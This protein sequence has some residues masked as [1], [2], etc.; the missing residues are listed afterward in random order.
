MPGNKRTTRRNKRGGGMFDGLL[1]SQQQSNAY[2]SSFG[3]SSLPV[4]TYQQQQPKQKSMFDSFSNMMPSFGSK[5]PPQSSLGLPS[6]IGGSRRRHR[7]SKSTKKRSSKR[8]SA[9]RG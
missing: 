6:Y 9:K 4:N 5:Q 7:K 8:K 3:D 1:G 2:N